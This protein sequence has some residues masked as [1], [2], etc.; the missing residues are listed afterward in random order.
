MELL[1]QQILQGL[2]T[3]SI[4]AMLALALVLG[5]R[6]T[7]VVNFAQGEMAMFA[8]F[9]A[10]AL[11]HRGVPVLA[12][13]AVAMLAAAASGAL[14]ERTL[15]RRLERQGSEHAAVL[16]TIGLLLA[17]NSL[18][19]LIWLY[20]PRDFPS[21]VP[22]HLYQL[23]GVTISVRMLGTV[24]VLV[25]IV[26][27]LFLLFQRT[28]LGLVMRAVAANPTSSR[29]VGIPVGR[30]LMLGWAFAGA[31]GALAGALVAPSLFLS[32]AMMTAVLGYALAAATLGGFDS[33]AGAVVGGL[34]L[35]VTENLAATY[36][37]AIGSDLKVLVPLVILV[38]TLLVRPRGLFG[39]RVLT[40]A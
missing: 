39:G 6:A 34:V 25:V 1:L 23:G 36:I 7:G 40:R 14:I 27:L 37:D 5:Y 3:G 31:L 2:A 4:Y 21:I 13:V 17:I 8:T 30:I 32:P 38:V 11:V 24:G 10:W 28:G 16:C 9:I 15:L 29:L 33:P 26:A 18:A 20:D 35:G 22:E 19:G 12:A